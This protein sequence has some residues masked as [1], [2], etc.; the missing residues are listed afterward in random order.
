[1]LT[2]ATPEGARDYLVP[3]RVHAG[4]FFALPQSPQLFK[5][6]LMIA[7]FDRYYQIVQVLPRR[8]PA[9]RPPA[10]VHADRHR[11][12]VPRR[13]TRSCDADGRPGARTSSSEVLG[14]RAARSVPAH[15]ATPRR[16]AATARTSRT[17]ASQLELTDVTDLVTDCDFKVFAGAGQRTRTAAWRRCACRAAARMPRSRDRRLHRVRRASTA[18][19]ASPTSR[20]TSAAKGRDGLQSPI[21]KFLQRRGAAR[22]SSS[23]PA[24]SD[25][26]LIFFG[27]DTRQGRERR[28]RRAAREDRPRTWQA[29][30]SDGWRPLWVVDF[31]MFEY[32]EDGEALGRRCTTRSPRPKDGHEDLLRDRSRQRRSPR[33][34]T[35]C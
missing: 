33:P 2:K 1:M 3:S 20:S 30:A 26:D 12:L 34:T 11:D 18:P 7:G 14:R 21:V 5:Q 6:L 17:C 13:R 28:A 8:G 31:P 9:R 23:A 10:R 22:A 24:R 15:D 29:R 16:C 4:K 19:R 35:W 25:G 32:D 27:A